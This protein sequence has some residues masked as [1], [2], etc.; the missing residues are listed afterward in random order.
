[1]AEIT[2]T[3]AIRSNLLQLQQTNMLMD[4]T[5]GRIASGKKVNSALDNPTAYFQAKGLTDNAK[6]LSVLK[7]SMGQSISTIQ[8]AD[9]GITAITSLVEQAKALA[10]SAKSSTS[11]TERA[12]L[13]VQFDDLRTQID[14]LANDATYTGKNLLS[15]RG[16][17]TGGAFADDSATAEGTL[18]GVSA[19]GIARTGTDTKVGTYVFT[20]QQKVEAATV[21]VSTVGSTP[22]TYTSNGIDLDIATAI[23]DGEEILFLV[24]D[25]ATGI[26]TTTTVTYT[27]AGT[28]TV[29]EFIT[30]VGAATG[31]SASIVSNEIDIVVAAG[32]SLQIKGGGNNTGSNF[33]TQT[34]LTAGFKSGTDV[35]T[36]IGA[37]G[38]TLNVYVGGYSRDSGST[39]TVLV[40][41]QDLVISDGTSSVRVK[42]ADFSTD[43]SPG[44]VGTQ[45]TVTI[46]D[47]TIYLDT[48]GDITALTNG[49]S[50]TVAKNGANGSATGDFQ[51]VVS[52]SGQTVTTNVDT[53]S[54]TTVSISNSAFGSTFNFKADDSSMVAGQTANVKVTNDTGD[55][56]NDLRV[57]FNAAGDASI[58]VKAVDVTALGL[59]INGAV[60]K[61]ATDTNV[62][63]AIT[64]IDAALKSLR[65][66][67]Q[68]LATNLGVIQT[69]EDFTDQFINTLQ[70]GADKLT[71]ADGNQEAS[72]ML[73][74]QTRQQLGIQALSM[75]SQSAQ[76]VLSLFR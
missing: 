4:M 44:N 40:D 48:K 23:T 6:D 36:A 50:T 31:L 74:L 39:I 8:S 46:N 69:R 61:W 41:S 16:V 60:S 56:A 27:D 14:K 13:A 34:G 2:L 66:S 21:T 25:N 35:S 15:G 30:A 11:A 3:A 42:F 19:G 26:V 58:N 12:D 75:A 55:G 17:V 53:S 59:L 5:Q 57:T 24:T 70:E 10:N 18:T 72:N 67:G 47:L 71:L 33:L 22:G 20:T 37:V 28:N 32:Y 64:E 1:M 54:S 68:A 51:I 73:M 63:S 43:T 7:D 76:A 62:S 45:Y 52:N 29:G 38:G 65:V 9:K 49:N